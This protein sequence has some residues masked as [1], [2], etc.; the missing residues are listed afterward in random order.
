M[1]VCNHYNKMS[2][3]KK[4]IKS[5]RL[6]LAAVLVPNRVLS[7]VSAQQ[8][9]VKRQAL[10][11]RRSS[12]SSASSSTDTSTFSLPGSPTVSSSPVSWVMTSANHEKV[13]ELRDR[14][15]S[16]A[17]NLVSKWKRVDDDFEIRLTFL[18]FHYDP[19]NRKPYASLKDFHSVCKSVDTF[20]YAIMLQHI[21]F[22]YLKHLESIN[23]KFPFIREMALQVIPDKQSHPWFTHERLGEFLLRLFRS[24][25]AGEEIPLRTEDGSTSVGLLDEIQLL[26]E[27]FFTVMEDVFMIFQSKEQKF[28]KKWLKNG[29]KDNVLPKYVLETY[30]KKIEFNEQMENEYKITPDDLSLKYVIDRDFKYL[31]YISKEYSPDWFLGYLDDGKSSLAHW[32]SHHDYSNG[33]LQLRAQKNVGYFDYPIEQVVKALNYDDHL[34]YTFSKWDY[35]DFSPIDANS[36]TQ[37]HASVLMVGDLSLGPLFSKRVLKLVCSS[38][39][40]FVANE[41]TECLTLFKSFDILDKASSSQENNPF[42]SVRHMTK[43][44][45]NRTRYVELRLGNIGGIVSSKLVISSP[46][47]AKKMATENYKG[48]LAAIERCE[49]EGFPMPPLETNLLAKTLWN[50]CKHYYNIDLQERWK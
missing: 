20:C 19:L 12:S 18:D 47:I 39:A 42:I 2:S 26:C 40:K 16:F 31:R 41:M 48:L 30:R 29:I 49:K 45:N 46:P 50:H 22:E 7:S 1:R 33:V 34:R 15:L 10:A 36:S 44:D 38:Q 14:F 32:T 9:R 21:P 37:K 17:K 24:I 6:P 5:V 25:K 13:E 3:L 43:S 4:S 27:M 11:P 23:D 35:K 28:V 8:H